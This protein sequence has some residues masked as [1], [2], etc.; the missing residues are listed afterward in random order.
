MYFF[1]KTLKLGFLN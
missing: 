1:K